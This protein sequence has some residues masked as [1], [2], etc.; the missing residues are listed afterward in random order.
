MAAKSKNSRPPKRL[1]PA[2]VEAFFDVLSQHIDPRSEL[3]WSSPLEMLVAVVLSAQTTD[4][5]VNKVT[6]ALFARCPS[7]SD[8]VELGEEGLQ[9]C[10]K[11][12]GLFRNKAKSVVGICRALVESHGGQVPATREELQALPGVGRKS[13]NVVLNVAFG[14]PTLAVDTH[15]FRVANRTGL[16]RAKTPEATELELLKIVPAK[17]LKAA[18]HY[19]ILHGRYTCKARQPDCGRCPVAASCNHRDKTA[20]E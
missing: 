11:S 5:Q 13:A 8:Y 16:V 1:S 14:Q 20:A 6:P 9:E 19:L 3:T 2:E 12:I 4:K 18:H 17:H 15:V 10:I 7:A